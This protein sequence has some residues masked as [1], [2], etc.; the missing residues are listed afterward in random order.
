[1]LHVDFVLVGMADMRGMSECPVLR[2]RCIASVC[3]FTAAL[4]TSISHH[5]QVI[6]ALRTLNI[7][8]S[9]GGG[10]KQKK[11][12]G[13]AGGGSGKEQKVG[14]LFVLG[15]QHLCI[16]VLAQPCSA[17]VYFGLHAFVRSAE[18]YLALCVHRSAGACQRS[19]R[20]SALN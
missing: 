17:V 20:G 8:A 7:A 5:F 18:L 19:V 3:C 1:M 10:G 11:G 15:T 6:K 12:K 2:C 9:G 14:P 13:G 16:R 4:R